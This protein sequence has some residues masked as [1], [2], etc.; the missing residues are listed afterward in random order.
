[1]K[2]F[3]VVIGL[4]LFVFPLFADVS[5]SVWNAL[6]DREVIVEKLDGS[7][8]RGTLIGVGDLDV[9]VM[10][11]DG[12]IVSVERSD[13]EEVRGVTSKP[14]KSSLSVQGDIPPGS[15]YFLFNPLGLLQTGPIFEYGFLVS[16]ELYIAPRIRVLG[17]GLLTQVL[18]GAADDDWLKIYSF[19]AGVGIFGQNSP[20]GGPNRVYYGGTLELGIAFEYGDVGTSYEWEGSTNMLITGASFGYKWR[21]PTR[22]FVNLGIFAGVGFTLSSDWYYVDDPGTVYQGKEPTYFV[23]GLELAVGWEQE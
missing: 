9:N 19:S 7:E 14:E 10:K 1:M 18:A 15:T 6:I 22:F 21:N 13:V 12:K 3:L 4:I 8:V 23:G 11:D 5:D 17:M 20:D 2:Q 16:P